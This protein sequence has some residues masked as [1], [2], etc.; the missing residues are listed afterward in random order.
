MPKDWC[1][2][3]MDIEANPTAIIPDLTVREYLQARNHVMSCDSCL[4]R[5]ER[6]LANH[7]DGNEI[8]FNQN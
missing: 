6:V 3:F 7:K 5:T 1:Q 4:T 2:F 8:R